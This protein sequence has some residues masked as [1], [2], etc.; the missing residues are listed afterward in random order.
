[1]TKKDIDPLEWILALVG[2]LMSIVFVS[3]V[4]VLAILATRTS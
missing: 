2:I 1:M 4:I 3:F